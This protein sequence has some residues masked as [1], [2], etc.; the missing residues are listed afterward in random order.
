V[1]GLKA[2]GC[3]RRS[4][5][6]SS[7][8]PVAFDFGSVTLQA[9]RSMAQFPQFQ[10]LKGGDPMSSA[11]VKALMSGSMARSVGHLA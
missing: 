6:R 7:I 9:A 4:L 8:H 3:I 5:Q 2:Q 1:I 10:Q 11:I